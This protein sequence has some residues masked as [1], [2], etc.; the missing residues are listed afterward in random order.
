M[1]CATRRG[2]TT[3][4]TT[5][6]ARHGAA[7]CIHDL[8]PRP[9]VGAHRSWTYVRFHGPHAVEQKYHG[10]YGAADCGRWPTGWPAWL[11]EGGD[12]YAY[13]NNDYDGHAVRDA[14]WLRDR[15]AAY[16][17]RSEARSA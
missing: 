6:C 15:L 10:R 3:R 1:S 16:L 11:D 17:P 8:L 14:G 4:S 5:C 9:P 7:L 12:V 13:F 2:C